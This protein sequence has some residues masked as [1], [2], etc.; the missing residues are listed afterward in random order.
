[1]ATLLSKMFR[2]TTSKSEDTDLPTNLSPPAV[3][4]KDPAEGP[5]QPDSQS[6]TPKSGQI[7]V[8]RDCE[9]VEIPGG[10]IH[11]LAAGAFVS[12][13]QALGGSYTLRVP[14]HGGLFRLAGQDA[15]AIG[16]EVAPAPE[17]TAEAI[18]TEDL[19]AEIWTQ[20]RTCFDPEIPVNIVD[21][22][23]IY[24][25]QVAPHTEGGSR[26]DVKMT[27]TAQGCGM[28]DSIAADAQTKIQRIPGVKAA[29]I[30]VVWDPPWT[31]DRMSEEGK[32]L[33]GIA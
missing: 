30:Q 17:A 25:L 19:E 11:P 8:T 15:D 32:T 27:L 23:L 9:V 5:S 24:D 26:V 29:D 33:L 2:R 6:S 31:P 20:L 28:G 4:L 22:G 3:S 10:R 7:Q 21:L 14:S 16:M 18:S 13:T 1:V 12:I